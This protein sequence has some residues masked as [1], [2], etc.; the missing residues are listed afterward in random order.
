MI[1]SLR[2]QSYKGFS[3]TTIKFSK[4]TCIIGENSTGKSTII[5]AIRD[6]L[7]SDNPISQ[8]DCK[9]GINDNNTTSLLLTLQNGMELS[10]NIQR[11]NREHPKSLPECIRDVN[12]IG[13]TYSFSLQDNKN[14][15]K[16]IKN[17]NITDIAWLNI[18]SQCDFTLEKAAASTTS[19]IDISK[20]EEDYTTDISEK[21]TKAFNDILGVSIGRK[22]KFQVFF[23][24][25][26]S[27]LV[28]Q[29]KIFYREI[30]KES[31]KRSSW[32]DLNYESPGFRTL[33]ALCSYLFNDQD[34]SE[35]IFVMD[36][37]FRDI[38]PK[39]QREVSR[40]LQSLSQ[41]FQI[42]YATHSPHLLPERD[43]V[44]CTLTET[45]GDL[46]ICKF[47]E[48]PLNR[49]YDLSPLALDTFEEIKMSDSAINVIPEGTTDDKIY[50]KLFEN[51]GISDTIHIVDMGGSGN[52]E[53]RIRLFATTDK[54]SLF[55]LD[56]NEKVKKLGRS[57]ELIAKHDHL[58]LL[59]LPYQKDNHVK[60]G[61]ENLIPNRIIEK[62]YKELE[63][64]VQLLTKQHHGEESTEEY[65][66]LQKPD[67]ADFFVNEA[68][69]D[70]YEFFK[71]VIEKI[72][73]IQNYLCENQI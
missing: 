23:A 12:P 56:P 51:K 1:Q 10:K 14:H 7:T 36:E 49:F 4:I 24:C 32:V 11:G 60:K 73:E 69:D 3:N 71:P 9:V 67:L 55:V 68:E 45:A 39:A 41:R 16:P 13:S 48:Y 58:F 52:L 53:N 5:R 43:N 6:L 2:L 17:Q 20:F 44:I 30:D 8:N 26:G 50:R 38:H 40:M 21:F 31:G 64:V 22:Y 54:P 25:D 66:I 34:K 33:I 42:I 27:H 59:E 57:R 15:N 47:E 62:A 18:L 37:P 46:S 35:K 72:K 63:Q 19:P 28:V 70:D 29:F 61:I 65:L